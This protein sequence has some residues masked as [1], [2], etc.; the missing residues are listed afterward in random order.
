MN[1]SAIRHTGAYPDSYLKDRNTLVLTLHTGR[2]DIAKCNL[3]IFPRTC[4]EDK[5]MLEMK[6]RWRDLYHDHYVIEICFQDVAHYQKYYFEVTDMEGNEFYVAAYGIS[7]KVPT[8]GFY[9]FL[10]ANQTEI[11]GLPN[12]CLGQTYYQIFPERFCNGNPDK[13]L[14]N[15]CETFEPWG[16]TP[17]RENYMGGDLQGIIDKLDYLQELGIECIYLNPIFVADFN[18]KYATT[19]YMDIDPLF[20]TK[21]LFKKLV[22]ELHKRKMKIIL[23]GVFNHSGIHFF[24]FEDLLEKQEN[25]EYKDWF[26]VKN[27]PIEVSETNPLYECVGDYGYMPK[28]NTANRKVREYIIDVM[29]YWLKEYRID[30]WRLDVA[31]EVD[32][33]VW[34]LARKELKELYPDSILL[35][36]TWGDG[37]RLMS[38]NQMDCIMNYVFR[39]AVRDFIAQDKID[40]L[41]FDSR[42]NRMFS[43]YPEQMAQAMFLPLDSHDT[44]RF[45]FLC[46]ENKQKMKLAVILQGL[47]LGSPSIY[48]GDE[49]GLTGDNDPDCRRCMKW[50]EENQDR[51]LLE[52]YKTVLELRKSYKCIKTGGY[53]ANICEGR[54]YG[55]ARSDEECEIYAV[56]NVSK[57]QSN[58]KV[59]VFYKGLYEE[60]ITKELYASENCGQE[61]YYNGDMCNYQGEISICLNAY[62]GKVLKRRQEK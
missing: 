28:L 9:E 8:D 57:T 27:Y 7:E 14:D 3:V 49:V 31:D 17:T 25:S 47:F 62:E 2:K 15:N 21:E 56:F 6:C 24:A 1:R 5:R 52:L 4:K 10:Y 12:W 58:V 19:D 37:L 35:G 34:L 30:G 60:M 18:H 11:V 23:D 33:G 50:D 38:G 42:V 44:E 22:D 48:Y 55:F 59:P 53:V 61:A 29:K 13:N 46:D 41:T 16:S 40:A 36:E 43:N 51:Q 20:G 26:Y 45:L 54:I 39:D 32:E